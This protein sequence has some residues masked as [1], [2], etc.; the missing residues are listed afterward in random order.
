MS[1]PGEEFIKLVVKRYSIE[2]QP[3]TNVLKDLS[4]R[5]GVQFSV[6]IAVSKEFLDPIISLNPSEA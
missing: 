4:R 2:K 5:L 6:E 3:F 1:L